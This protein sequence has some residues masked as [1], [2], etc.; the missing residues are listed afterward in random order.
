MVTLDAVL[1]FDSIEAPHNVYNEYVAGRLA[2]AIHAPIATGV[3][4]PGIDG[5]S[6]AS[7]IVTSPGEALLDLPESRLRD[8]ALS[9]PNEVAA[10]VAF[11]LFIGNWDR[12]R[13]LK[14]SLVSPHIR[15]FGAF[16]HSHALLG[17][18]N[19]D[20]RESIRQLADG[21]VIVKYH[22]FFGLVD[23]AR[24]IEWT[25]RIADLS[26][27]VIKSSCQM[28][29]DFRTVLVDTQDALAAALIL[30]RTEIFR[31]AETRKGVFE[32]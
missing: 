32:V 14:V 5:P 21:D 18:A 3:L 7:L 8:V 1:K 19:A 20:P 2:A 13:N 17:I 26:K 29:R 15:V 4:T 31:L 23:R 9:Y 16:D 24:F 28:E 25:N 22:P 6:F 11:D 10:L 27:T 30:R 12:A